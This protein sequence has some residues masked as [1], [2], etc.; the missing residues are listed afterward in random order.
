MNATTHHRRPLARILSATAIGALAAT[1]ALFPTAAWAATTTVTIDPTAFTRT[2]NLFD[3]DAHPVSSG[4]TTI[5]VD[6]PAMIDTVA[7]DHE[8]A[9]L[10]GTVVTVSRQGT[11]ATITI[12]SGFW[13]SHDVDSSMSLVL[14]GADDD[15][16][17]EPL[18][19]SDVY[20]AS[21][22]V[23][24]G[25]PGGGAT[26]ITS[27]GLDYVGTNTGYRPSSTALPVEP[28]DTV[29]LEAEPGFWTSGPVA[30][31]TLTDWET[32]EQSIEISSDGS[33]ATVVVGPSRA[34]G[35]PSGFED[36]SAVASSDFDAPVSETIL[37]V[38]P[39]DFP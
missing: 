23:T 25:A 34:A 9:E 27:D 12:P 17:L 36:L 26:E 18:F 14:R 10:D 1:A 22:T 2:T 39:L 5:T 13:S 24:V 30:S 15:A 35:T 21:F 3:F 29:V 38:V 20:A 28:G 6:L 37:V 8:S 11:L 33:T 7:Y 16:D 19:L 32:T 4:T 31:A